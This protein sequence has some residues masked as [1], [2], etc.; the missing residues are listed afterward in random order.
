[1]T[2]TEEEE[3]CIDFNGVGPTTDL[4]E[5]LSRNPTAIVITPKHKIIN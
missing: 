2:S 5:A 4:K 3:S 1:M